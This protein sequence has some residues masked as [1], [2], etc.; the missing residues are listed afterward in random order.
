MGIFKL[1]GNYGNKR[2][3]NIEKIKLLPLEGIEVNNDLKILF[4]YSRTD[5]EVL[6][7]QLLIK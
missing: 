1:V 2:Y 6:L 4:K 7:G 3:I 5:I